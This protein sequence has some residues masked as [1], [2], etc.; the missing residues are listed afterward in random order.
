ML[1]LV[2]ECATTDEVWSIYLP[3]STSFVL[4]GLHHKLAVVNL[5]TILYRM[6]MGNEVGYKMCSKHGYKNEV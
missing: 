3:W 2:T 6:Y 1:V 4:M 5:L